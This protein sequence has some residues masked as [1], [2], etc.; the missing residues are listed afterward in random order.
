M[1]PP[2]CVEELASARFVKWFETP[3]SKSFNCELTIFVFNTNPS[4]FFKKSSF[5]Q[6]PIKLAME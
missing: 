2:P 1:C 3:L 4:F 5:L 6:L